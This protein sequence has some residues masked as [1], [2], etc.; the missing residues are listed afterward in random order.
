MTTLPAN[1]NTAVI[2]LAAGEGKRMQSE[3]PKVMHELNGKPLIDHVVSA[4]EQAGFGKPVVV[5]SAKNSLVQ[6]YLKERATYVVQAEQKGTGHAVQCAK[7]ILYTRADTIVVL[8]GDMPFLRAES[9]QRLVEQHTAEHNAVT[10]MT[11]QVPSYE[12]PYAVFK[13]FGRIIRNQ[14]GRIL[15]S[16]EV[17]DATPEELASL[18][19]NPCY[20]CFK[21]SWLWSEIEQLKNN[22]DQGEYYLTDL[23]ERGIATERA[24]GM[25]IDP[26]EALGVN[27]KEQLLALHS[28]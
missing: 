19:V 25:L 11:V 16:V 2:I 28:I 21:A 22:N 14:D 15:K 20:F 10:L 5:V 6:D 13:D 1:A 26:R 7:E 27:T 3:L 12:G 9:I 17:R 8:Y 23:I 4:V 18:E 24:S